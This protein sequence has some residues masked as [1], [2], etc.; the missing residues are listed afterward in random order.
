MVTGQADGRVSLRTL[1]AGVGLGAISD[2][3]TEAPQLIAAT[4]ISLLQDR[5]KGVTIAVDV[6]D[7]RD[8]HGAKGL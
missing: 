2:Q 4:G 8:P 3:I 7:D 6:R 1:H 5:V